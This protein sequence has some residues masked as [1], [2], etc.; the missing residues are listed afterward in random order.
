[1]SEQAAVQIFEFRRVENAGDAGSPEGASRIRNTYDPVVGASPLQQQ[2]QDMAGTPGKC[3][4]FD[5]AGAAVELGAVLKA[6]PSQL[7]QWFG[8]AYQD[9]KLVITFKPAATFVTPS[10]KKKG[11]I[12]SASSRAS[13]SAASDGDP[14]SNG[15]ADRWK[16]VRKLVADLVP[17]CF[18]QK[19]SGLY[20]LK[21][22]SG[23]WNACLQ[24]VILQI[25][26]TG[27][28]ESATE[29]QGY[30]LE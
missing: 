19:P 6:T 3:T 2:L 9:G 4:F 25:R 10:S 18:A 17:A 30:I 26:K 8:S 22:D 24:E 28:T 16:D 12:G 20:Y 21:T 5:A 23:F 1:M 13:S 7:V 29:I 15:K 27:V 14:D 11:K